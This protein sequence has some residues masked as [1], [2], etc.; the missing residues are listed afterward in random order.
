MVISNYTYALG[1]AYEMYGKYLASICDDAQEWFLKA[2]ECYSQWGAIAKANQLRDD[3]GLAFELTG[4]NSDGMLLA[5][6]KHG[7][8]EDENTHGEENRS[9]VGGG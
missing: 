1:L 6:E 9:K 3:H 8:D 5:S 2:H 4:V 7:R